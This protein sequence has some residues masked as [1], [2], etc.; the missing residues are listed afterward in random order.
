MNLAAAHVNNHLGRDACN[1]MLQR[2]TESIQSLH[3][4][5]ESLKVALLYYAKLI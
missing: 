3:E 4:Q 1:T 2:Q 5:L